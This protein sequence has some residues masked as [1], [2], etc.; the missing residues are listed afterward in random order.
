MSILVKLLNSLKIGILNVKHIDQMNLWYP[1]VK[2][3]SANAHEHVNAY[4]NTNFDN[5]K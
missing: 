3:L 1:F 2:D 4:P 5:H